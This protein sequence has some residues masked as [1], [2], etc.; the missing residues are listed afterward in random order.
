M[1]P[2]PTGTSTT[3]LLYPKAPEILWKMGQQF[4]TV[5]GTGSLLQDGIPRNTDPFEEKIKSYE[6][7]FN[8]TV[9]IQLIFF[10]HTNHT[11]KVSC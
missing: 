9:G 8:A 5:S 11:F 10:P 1:V 6:P 2:A 4:L 7:E 3:Q